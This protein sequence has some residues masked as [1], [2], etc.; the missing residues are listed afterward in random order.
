MHWLLLAKGIALRGLPIIICVLGHGGTR[1]WWLLATCNYTW[2]ILTTLIRLT[3]LCSGSV[4]PWYTR[5]W[6]AYATSSTVYFSC[7]L[8]W[9]IC[10][11]LWLV[12]D[13]TLVADLEMSFFAFW[14]TNLWLVLW[15]QLCSWLRLMYKLIYLRVRAHTIYLMEEKMVGL[16]WAHANRPAPATKAMLT[17]CVALSVWLLT[18]SQVRLTAHRSTFWELWL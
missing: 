8:W 12:I 16:I 18:S 11:R 9:Q 2:N 3:V 13:W 6:P 14:D 4:L 7:I 15:L 17:I 1:Y 5:P 10:R